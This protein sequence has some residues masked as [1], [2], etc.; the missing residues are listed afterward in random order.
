MM[1]SLQG[2]IRK[3]EGRHNPRDRTP[4]RVLL[5]KTTRA[6]T[7]R[8]GFDSTYDGAGAPTPESETS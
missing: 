2:Q 6:R 4:A 3:V 1:S 5:L 8:S 7:R